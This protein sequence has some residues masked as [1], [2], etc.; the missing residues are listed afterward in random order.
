[1]DDEH[2]GCIV[3]V[4]IALLFLI[5]AGVSFREL[6]YLVASRTADATDATLGVH[7]SRSRWGN[8]RE[9]RYVAYT[10]LDHRDEHRRGESNVSTAWL[11]P[12]DAPLRIQYLSGNPDTN[13]LDGDVSWLPVLFFLG[14]S[15]ALIVSGVHL[16]RQAKQDVVRARR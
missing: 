8:R 6:R 16:W 14:C 11:P 9:T 5:S 13:R 1:M 10:F 4:V 2:K 7:Q 15:A 3:F 12:E